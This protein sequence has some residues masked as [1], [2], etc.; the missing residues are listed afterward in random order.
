LAWR[1]ENC[2]EVTIQK[3]D[4]SQVEHHVR[5]LRR[6]SDQN[7]QNGDD[8]A[9]PDDE[10][11]ESAVQVAASHHAAEQRRDRQA[12]DGHRDGD[13]R[14]RPNVERAQVERL[15]QRPREDQE[16]D[17]AVG[18]EKGKQRLA[19]FARAHVEPPCE[20]L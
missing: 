16:R 3:P 5:R 1:I 13:V 6:H 9:E 10:G 2:S 7:L 11:R 14:Q 19:A 12:Q 20:N 4:V 8:D 18:A 15:A 17:H